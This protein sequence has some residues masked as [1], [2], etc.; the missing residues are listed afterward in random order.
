[1]DL[2]MVLYGSFKG[3]MDLFMVLWIYGSFRGYM[4]LLMDLWI[5]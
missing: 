2:F 5:I 1:M 3:S 4:D